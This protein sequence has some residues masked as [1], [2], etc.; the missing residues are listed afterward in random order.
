MA[1]EIFRQLPADKIYD[2][3]IGTRDSML[4]GKTYYPAENDKDQVVAYNYGISIHDK[5]YIY[6]SMFYETGQRGTSMTEIRIFKTP[7]GANLVIV[8]KTS[9]VWQVTYGQ[10][11]LS[12]FIYNKNKKL[13][14][15]KKVVFPAMD[16]RIFMKPGIPDSARKTILNNSNMHFDFSH[17]KVT[18][19]LSSEFITNNIMIRKLLKGNSIYFNWIKDRFVVGEIKFQS[20]YYP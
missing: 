12:Y 5:N 19:N 1:L 10:H 13:V 11:E 14:P 3:T 16:E 17:K 6:V 20:L 18:L 9:G 4:Q 8:S 7:N 15:Y 2:L